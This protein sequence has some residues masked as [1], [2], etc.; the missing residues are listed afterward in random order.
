[1]G[2]ADDLIADPDIAAIGRTW[3]VQFIGSIVACA[4]YGI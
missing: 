2:A 4:K 1:L 3:T